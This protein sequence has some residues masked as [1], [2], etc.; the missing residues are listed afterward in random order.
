MVILSDVERMDNTNIQL[1]VTTISLFLIKFDW[2]KF[3]V[4]LSGWL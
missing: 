4:T 3:G 1:F 2:G